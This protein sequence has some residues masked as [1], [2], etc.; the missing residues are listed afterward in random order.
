MNFSKHLHSLSVP[1]SYLNLKRYLGQLNERDVAGLRSFSMLSSSRMNSS[2]NHSTRSHLHTSSIHLDQEVVSMTGFRHGNLN[3]VLRSSTANSIENNK[4]S[5]MLQVIN[6]PGALGDVLS[7]FSKYL[8]NMTRIESKPSKGKSTTFDITIDFDGRPGLANVDSLFS[9][10]KKVCANYSI[11]NGVVVPW[12]PTKISDIDFFSQKTLDAGAEIE[13]DH[14][15]FS[16]V[17]YRSRRKDIV[18]AAQAYKHGQSI[19]KVSYSKN[20]IDTWEIVYNK[21]RQYTKIHAIDSYNHI[22]P[23]ME[24][25]CGYA[26][27]NIPQLQDVSD[28][29]KHRTGWTIRPVGGLLSARDFLNGLAYKVFFSTQYIRH[30]SAPLYTPE[31]DI[32]HELLG[33]APMFA[34]EDFANFSHEIGLASLGAS[35]AD[36][37][38]L[39]TCYWFSVEFGLANQDGS[40][41]AYGAGLLSSFGELEFAC[42]PYRPAG[43]SDKF[44]EY[45]SWDPFKAS[46]QEYPIT[47]YQPVYYV[48]ESLSDAKSKMRSFIGSLPR[49]FSVVYDEETESV[50]VDRAIIRGQYTATLQT[51]SY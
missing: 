10:L 40:K 7:L 45:R 47:T 51:G 4:C 29:L 17:E 23:L 42:A 39:A 6:K 27:K 34:D 36:I 32:C 46:V 15:G 14:P 28:F 31:P 1:K 13:S 20:E 16:D 19:P 43:G 41:K 11:V 50:S 33:H 44:P 48:A 24:Q 35:D 26:S 18:E 25:H 9:D 21:L 37:K 38:K 2:L 12:F 22:L 30:Y 8:V 5:I 3:E 49:G